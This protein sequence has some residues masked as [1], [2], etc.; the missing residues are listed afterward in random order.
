MKPDDFRLVAGEDALGDYRFN[1]MQA[2]NRFC[3]TCGVTVY[4]HGHI[5]AVGGDFVSVSVAT[6][7]DLDPADARRGAGPLHGRAR[8]Q[9]VERAGGDAAR[10]SRH[11]C[12]DV[13]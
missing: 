8:R 13:D 6:L 3:R 11:Q 7:D 9:L 5:E 2:H 12:R 10:S 4:G 1:T